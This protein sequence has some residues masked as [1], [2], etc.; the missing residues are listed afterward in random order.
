MSI[1]RTQRNHVAALEPMPGDCVVMTR[2]GSTQAFA[3]ITQYDAAV[4]ESVGL[5]DHIAEH[6]DVVPMG[7]DDF[8]QITMGFSLTDFL[9]ALPPAALEELRQICIDA[10][11][12]AIRN[13]DDVSAEVAAKLLGRPSCSEACAYRRPREGAREL[14]DYVR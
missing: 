6:I 14:T 10:C 13:D 11:S 8:V 2:I 5:A 4:R 3:P 12:K 7:L 1:I 9:H